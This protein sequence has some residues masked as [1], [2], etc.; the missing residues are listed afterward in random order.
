[1]N[2]GKQQILFNYLPGKTFDFERVAT[3]ARVR[4]VRGTPQT[5]LN[6]AV[7]LHKIFEDVRAWSEEF[8]PALRDD[9]VNDPRRFVLLDPVEV[10]AE[11]FPKVFWCQNQRSCG[12]VFDY[13]NSDSL[14][15]RTC[16]ACGNGQ[17]NQLR[18]IKIHRC[19]SIQPLLPPACP[20]CRS[21]QNM[22]L[23]TRG[24]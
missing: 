5:E 21:S 10:Q 15:R 16:T 3:I 4:G 24:S 17:L 7:L 8:R 6:A 12:R 11:M 22:G 14:P 1:M 13:T 19:G 9:I 18:F 2:R 20:Q 23:D